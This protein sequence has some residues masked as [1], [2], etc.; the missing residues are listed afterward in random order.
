MTAVLLDTARALLLP[1]VERKK[2]P[3]NPER[4]LV[5]G[6]AAIG[7]LIFFL[8]VLEG[9][10]RRWP[11]AKVVFLANPYPTTKELLPATKLADEIWLHDAA[12]ASRAER[13]NI[14][15][16]IVEG[17]FDLAV[18]TLSAPAHHFQRGLRSIPVVAGHVRGFTGRRG[19]VLGER[20]RAALL[21]LAAEPP[22]VGE[23]ALKRNLRLLDLLG[24]AH[25]EAP[26]PELPV[27]A[28]ADLPKGPFVAVHLGAPN[29]QYEKMWR[30]ERFAELC[31][32]LKGTFVLV[33]G[34]DER[35]SALEAKKVFPGFV[36]LVGRYSLLETFAALK[37]AVLYLGNDTGLAKAAAALGTPTASVFGPSDPR[38]YGVGLWEPEKHLDIRTGI[39]CSPCSFMGMAKK[40]MLNY[41]NCGHH[42]CLRQLDAAF[43]ARA[44]ASKWPA[45]LR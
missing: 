28:P 24:I 17:R 3:L 35:T 34:P 29:D 36:D 44:L 40:G 22:Y 27:K 8:P 14:N 13:K 38:E 10:R 5:L 41:S 7:D 1:K 6:Y 21:D 43:A 39:A 31:G 33:G 12:Q 20:A 18:L 4:I 25:E 32:M 23:H 19:L 11:K 37:A 30:P 16:K 42:N 45:L 26:R 15:A 2:T 9:L